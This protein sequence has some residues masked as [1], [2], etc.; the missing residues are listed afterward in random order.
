MKTDISNWGE[1]PPEF[2]QLLASA[3]E[4]AGSIKSVAKKLDISRTSASLLLSNKYTS[5]SVR[6]M[7]SKILE[8]L[9]V[10]ECPELGEIAVQTCR[11]N[12]AVQFPPNH[13]LKLQLWR[14]CSICEHNPA[15]IKGKAS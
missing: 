10:V 13:P 5:P 14:S 4:E 1:Q 9:G 8:K 11:K 3:V 2:I 12:C 15:S 6:K 7:E